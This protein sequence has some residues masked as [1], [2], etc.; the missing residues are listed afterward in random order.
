MKTYKNNGLRK[1]PRFQLKQLAIAVYGP[2]FPGNSLSTGTYFV[3]FH[4]IK[5]T[6]IAIFIGVR[7]LKDT[8]MISVVAFVDNFDIVM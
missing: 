4:F 6:K 2:I 5:S 1:C 7:R 8:A 3:G